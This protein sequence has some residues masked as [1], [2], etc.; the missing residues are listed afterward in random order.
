MLE[1]SGAERRHEIGRVQFK[2]ELSGE[3]KAYRGTREYENR[4]EYLT[5]RGL[6]IWQYGRD[7]LAEM[8][9][10]LLERNASGSTLSQ[11]QG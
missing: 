5:L 3:G 4:S 6:L 10:P 11:E 9:E 2:K 7:M 8:E 1:N